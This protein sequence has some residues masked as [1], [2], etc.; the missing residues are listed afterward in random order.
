MRE[1]HRPQVDLGSQ[2]TIQIDRNTQL[3]GN[4]SMPAPHRLTILA[5]DLTGAADTG[6]PFA[7]AGFRTAVVLAD[8]A[9]TPA[10]EIIVV[11]TNSRGVPAATAAQATHDAIQQWAPTGSRLGWVY[12][13][14]DSA[15]RGHP[16]AEVEAAMTACGVR[17][18]LVAPALPQQG[19]TTVGGRQHLDGLPLE[20]TDFGALGVESDLLAIF[21]PHHTGE[22]IALPL[23]IV[24]QGPSA[25]ASFVASIEAG[26]IIADAETSPDLDALA[27][28][29]V[30]S[31]PGLIAGT[32]GLAHALAAVLPGSLQRE[33]LR[34]PPPSAG[35]IL[36][37]AGSR[38]AATA[39]QVDH[40]RAHGTPIVSLATHHLDDPAML[41]TEVVTPLA[42]MVASGSAAVL[43]TVGLASPAH[44]AADIRN[45]L[46]A[47]A[48]ALVTTGSISGLVLTGGD[49][50]M[51]VLANL[52]VTHIELGGEVRPAM[53][54]GIGNL[55]DGHRVPL[56]TKAGSFGD[57][58]ALLA[59][60]A[61]LG[62]STD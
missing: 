10:T 4:R 9:S 56:A 18:V 59:C 23:A 55:S 6:A 17:K 61:F 11:N 44:G 1:A 47:I 3:N 34:V 15:L 50:A 25:I 53:P 27:Q 33:P 21:D 41:R 46:A 12:K 49:V 48:S 7:A 5:D 22:A 38:D 37:I 58:D 62:E 8:Q 39:R 26:V 28:A 54:W 45:Q 29:I 20:E 51:G 24:R 16:R 42:D 14:I 32:A 19:R 2:A 31:G 52:G 36:V 57:A 13:K 43:T 35:G 30:Q 60:L 40:L